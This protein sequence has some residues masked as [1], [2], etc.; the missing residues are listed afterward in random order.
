ML[1]IRNTILLLIPLFVT[2][3][4]GCNKGQEEDA[5]DGRVYFKDIE[6]Y[7]IFGQTAS[8]WQV[9]AENNGAGFEDVDN[10]YIQRNDYETLTV[11][12]DSIYTL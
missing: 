11:C 2:A 5:P 8:D 12:R 10:W 6:Y 7:S 3:I 4:S 1:H 9:F